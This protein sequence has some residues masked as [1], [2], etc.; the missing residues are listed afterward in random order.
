MKSVPYAPEVGSLI[1]T[2]VATRPDI[3][4]AVGVVDRFMHN[5][6]RSH[7]RSK[8]VFRYPNISTFDITS[9]GTASFEGKSV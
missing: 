1:N 9:F 2:M 6:G 7:G 5:P 3:A 4:H 8:H